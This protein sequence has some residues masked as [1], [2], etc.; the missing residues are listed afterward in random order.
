MKIVKNLK[1]LKVLKVLRTLRNF[2]KTRHFAAAADGE[3]GRFGSFFFCEMSGIIVTLKDFTSEIVQF[4]K[5][6]GTL[7]RFM[8]L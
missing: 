2:K 7:I 3:P 1:V 5:K 4:E 6:I 8:K